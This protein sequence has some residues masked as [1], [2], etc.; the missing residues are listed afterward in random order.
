MLKGLGDMANILKMQKEMK[1]FQKK[2]MST[3]IEG[4]SPDGSVKAVVNGGFHLVRLTIE[5]GLL[6]SGGAGQIEKGI[7]SAVNDAVEK[8]KG[9]SAAEMS[10]LTGGLNIPDFFK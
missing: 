5:G 4:A 3:E 9:Y 1:N 6:E 2:L 10:R 8:I 7:I